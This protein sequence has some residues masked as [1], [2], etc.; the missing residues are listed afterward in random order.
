MKEVPNPEA[1]RYKWRAEEEFVNAIRGMEKVTRTPFDA[2]VQ[3]MEF[4]EAVARSAQT[5]EAVYLSL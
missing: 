5:G 1:S 3:Y 4:S 2:G